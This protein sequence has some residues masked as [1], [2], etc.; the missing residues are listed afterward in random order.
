MSIY[1]CSTW[2][3]LVEVTQSCFCFTR[4]LKQKYSGMLAARLVQSLS[5]WSSAELL[6]WNTEQH[7]GLTYSVRYWAWSLTGL[8]RSSE[9][10][11]VSVCATV[12]ARTTLKTFLPQGR[13]CKMYKIGLGGSIYCKYKK[14]G[15]VLTKTNKSNHIE[16]IYFLMIISK[17]KLFSLW[18]NYEIQSS[19][20]CCNA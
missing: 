10:A 6:D 4:G 7:S 3:W 15:K 12:K 13:N 18:C 19:V 2:S 1:S 11:V 9:T 5:L 16:D 14:L 20:L 17:L 8:L